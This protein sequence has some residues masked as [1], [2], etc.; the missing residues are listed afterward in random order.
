MIDRNSEKKRTRHFAL[1]VWFSLAA[2]A[3]LIFAAGP[4]AAGVVALVNG[5]PVTAV[6]VA[7]R[8]KL[9]ETLL[10]KK[11]SKKEV[12]DELINEKI[13][14]Q[15]A[16]HKNIIITDEQ[17]DEALGNMAQRTG[18]SR[19]AFIESL[20][21]AGIDLSRF[22]SR[23][24][25]E[26]AWRQLLQQQSPGIFQVRDADLVAILTA[27][28]EQPQTKATEY[29][30]QPIILVVSRRAPD[31]VRVARLKEAE[32]LRSRSANC[33]DA[34]AMAREL[35]EVV[36]KDPL[37]RLSTGLGEQYK[38]LLDNTPDGKMTP[39]EVT[40]SGIELVAICSRKEVIADIS[41]R[42]EFRSA[43]LSR[44]ISDF[45]KKYL[46]QLRK[47]SIIEYR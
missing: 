22:R 17:V 15:E 36:V 18:R 16:K 13:E 6:D 14:L 2:F 44:R 37:V 3:F 40:A 34:V 27:R 33:E 19:A 7:Q 32:S 1:P 12:L 23:T 20:K 30:L 31:S 9:N 24:R 28:G 38:K 21:R 8:L 43:L 4:A 46:E 42:K 45:E 10:Q 39:P 25:A 35:R 29:S 41:S 5:E 26:Y 47:Q 11:S